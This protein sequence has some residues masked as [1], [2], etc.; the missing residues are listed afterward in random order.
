MLDEA[1]VRAASA[2]RL[3]ARYADR[4]LSSPSSAA[5]ATA[6]AASLAGHVEPALADIGH[7]RWAGRTFVE[8]EQSESAALLAWLADPATGA[9]DGE[10]MDAAKLRIG[11][12]L[13]AI[14]GADTAI[15]AITHPM[16]VRA[17]LSHALG[18]PLRATLAI[19]LA[20]LSQVRLSFNR[21]WR[22]Q[23]LGRAD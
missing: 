6:H 16:I 23:S 19:D 20:P 11:R 3:P 17:A 10:T 5:E 18:I 8:I 12:W 21:L 9:P 4:I 15:C 14:S 13:D 22:L 2:L 1:G 7:G